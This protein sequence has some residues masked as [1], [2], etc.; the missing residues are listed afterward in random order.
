MFSTTSGQQQFAM[1]KNKGSKTYSVAVV[2]GR[3]QF[4][5][6]RDESGVIIQVADGI[7]SIIMKHVHTDFDSIRKAIPIQEC[8]ISPV[9]HLHAY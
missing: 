5:R 9:V 3:R 4:V 2:D 7:K 6:S 8:L 1:T